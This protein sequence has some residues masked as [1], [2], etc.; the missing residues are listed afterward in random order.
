MIH[1]LLDRPLEG[2]RAI[3]ARVINAR[4]A[5]VRV[6]V[7]REIDGFALHALSIVHDAIVE[8]TWA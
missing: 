8:F 7:S 6:G 2:V 4:V 3:I 1:R 5:D